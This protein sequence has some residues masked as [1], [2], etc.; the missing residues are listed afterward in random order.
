MNQLTILFSLLV[1]GIVACQTPPSKANNE[2]QE[3][4]SNKTAEVVVKPDSQEVH[5]RNSLNTKKYEDKQVFLK[6]NLKLKKKL[7]TVKRCNFMQ[8]HLLVSHSNDNKDSLTYAIEILTDSLWRSIPI[9]DKCVKNIRCGI[10]LYKDA[11]DFELNGVRYWFAMGTKI[12]GGSV[13]VNINSSYLEIKK[14]SK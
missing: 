1:F 14:L 9:E 8:Q 3:A 2:S 7:H 13:E 11:K 12:S 10:Y 4:V 6:R 5:V